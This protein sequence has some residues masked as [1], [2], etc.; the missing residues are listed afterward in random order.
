MRNDVVS[1]LTDLVS[2]PS[3]NPMGR[4]A[5]GPEFFEHQMTDYLEGFFRELKVPY[6]RQSVEPLRENIIARIDG[7]LPTSKGGKLI[8]LEA[9]Q[10]TVPVAGMTIEP[11]KPLI[12]DGRLY[13]R[14]SCDIKGGMA[15]MLI[16][17]ARL[18]KE[19][20]D[21]MPTVIMACTVNEEF[22]FGGAKEL[23][24]LWQQQS[25]IF[26]R[27]PD[28][29]IIAEPTELDVV[30]AHK[31]VVRWRCHTHGRAAHSSQPHLGDSAIFRM[32][33][34]LEAL[35]IYQH[36]TVSR[37]SQHALCGMPTLS[38]G[39]IEGGLS[40]N[41]V[42]D[43]CTVEID[44]RC[45][46]GED[47]RKAYRHAL[48][49]LKNCLGADPQVKHDEPFSESLGLNDADNGQLAKRLQSVAKQITGRCEIVGVPYGTDAATIAS[50]GIPAVVF[51]PGS[52]DQAHT[53]DE[54]IAI[55]QL[56][57]A[58]EIYYQF[59]KTAE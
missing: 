18:A 10:D 56:H 11:W 26:P 22:G 59:C 43:H 7:A 34:V 19:M 40:V 21:D 5:N 23:P 42:P 33:R 2:H 6:V 28:I 16:A 38:V 44:R 57:L 35:E 13:G 25:E 17:F 32:A 27:R 49:Y 14:G 46:P 55:D 30:T 12:R 15:A 1:L 50:T 20:P 31:G 48:D 52:I 53:A 54:W 8:M 51:G 29:A 37:L 45:V 9:H 41:T 24:K 39:T 4:E 58:T 36:D 47:P 3:V